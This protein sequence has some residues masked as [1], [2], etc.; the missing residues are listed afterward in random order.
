MI[1]W[2]ILHGINAPLMPVGHE[3]VQ[4][5][6]LL[7]FGLNDRDWLPGAAFLSWARMGNLQRWAGPP[8]LEW[9]ANQAVLALGS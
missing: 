8:N 5:R 7:D 1:D 6:M 9:M 2:M 3:E 4:R